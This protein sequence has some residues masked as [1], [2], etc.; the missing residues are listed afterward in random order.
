MK[1]PD[2]GVTNESIQKLAPE[3]PPQQE[4]AKDQNPQN[5][6]AT[7]TDAIST[8][9]QQESQEVQPEAELEIK[10]N[11]IKIS[12]SF[13]YKKFFKMIKFGVSAQAVKLKMQSEGFDSEK[14][15]HPDELVEKCPEDDVE[16]E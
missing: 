12:E 4:S 15:D 10:L 1:I 7:E 2:E 13:Q 3:Q 8:D 5:Q 14:L 9:T 16:Q 11:F 6:K